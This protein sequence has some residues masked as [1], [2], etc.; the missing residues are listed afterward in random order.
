[1]RVSTPKPAATGNA[2]ARAR[3]ESARWPG[4]RL[5]HDDASPRGDER[6]R[7]ALR[8]A[9]PLAGAPG[10]R[11]DHEVGAAVARLLADR[12]A[13]PEGRDERGRVAA[14]VGITEQERPRRARPLGERQ[15][16]ALA[17]PLERH[18]ASPRAA[19]LR[20]GRVPRSVV[21]DDDLGRRERPPQRRDRVGDPLLLVTSGD[22]DRE[23]PGG[24]RLGSTGT[25]GRTP[26]SALPPSP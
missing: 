10:E 19:R 4:E 26:S 20:G 7:D 21:G 11:C 17:A 16:L 1:M 13:A 18:D 14:Q 5:A 8:D 12:R 23:V 15:R 9:E 3:S 25:G 2:T 6:P 24:H 22:E